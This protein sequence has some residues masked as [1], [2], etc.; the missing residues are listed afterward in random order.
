[1]F[2]RL[3]SIALFFATLYRFYILFA[4]PDL[5]VEDRVKIALSAVALGFLSWLLRMYSIY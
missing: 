5:S 3:L 4:T 1:M 2:Y